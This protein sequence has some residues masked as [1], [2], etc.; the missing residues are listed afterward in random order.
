[1]RVRELCLEVH[2]TINIPAKRCFDVFG[3]YV[4]VLKFIIH[5]TL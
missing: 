2:V 1:M 4:N 3:P 5:T